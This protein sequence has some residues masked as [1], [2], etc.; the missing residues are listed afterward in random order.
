MNTQLPSKHKFKRVYIF[1]FIFSIALSLACIRWQIVDASKFDEIQRSRTYSSEIDSLRGSIYARDGSTLAHSVPTFDVYVWMEDINFFERK[2]IQTKEEFIASVAPIIDLTNEQLREIISSN[3][4]SGIKWFRIAKGVSSEQWENLK[5]TRIPRNN[6]AVKGLSYKYTSQRSYPED[7]LAAHVLGLTTTY[8]DSVIGEGGL[9]GHWN[10]ILNPVK[11]YLIKEDNAYGEAVP[12]ALLPTVE[13]KNGSSIYTSID[14][15]LQ[16]IVEEKIKWGVEKY[17]A[18]SG[19]IIIM[20]PKTGQILAMANW[21]TYDPNTR[22]AESNAYANISVSSPFEVGSIGKVFT[23][24]A[25]IDNG[26]ITPETTI[27]ESG[28]QGCESIHRDLLPVCTWDKKPQ[29]PMP[30]KECFAI[31]DNLC[32]Y[33]IAEKMN[34]ADFY[35][36]LVKFGVGSPTGVDIDGES[37]GL[38]KPHEQWNTG[39]VSAFS[40]GHGYQINSLQA[41][42]GVAAIGNNGVR[43]KPYI[44]TKIVDGEGVEK[45]FEPQIVEQVV[46]KETTA[47]VAGMMHDIYQRSITDGEYYYH[48]LR[49]YPIAM[50]SGTALIATSQGYTLDINATYIGFDASE[51]HTFA[52]LVKLEKPQVPAYDRLSFYNARLVWLETFDAVKDQLGVPKK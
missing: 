5:N 48:H 26:T 28:H 23:I 4:E 21:P 49:D 24:A 31:S 40:Y 44:V 7:S 9:E 12:T 38:L 16:E 13:P 14:K 32:F 33:H 29:P 6:V 25:A 10:G 8:K 1:A 34:N 45:E 15:S 37:F 27:M 47:Q 52:M 51:Q 35:N 46:S 50:K 19:S 22:E 18:E 42:S 11:G 39:D 43:M 30:A 36:Y 2:G 3:E 17:E 20:D 41:L